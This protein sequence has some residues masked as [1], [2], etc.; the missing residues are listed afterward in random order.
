MLRPDFPFS[1]VRRRRAQ[2]A[3]PLQKVLFLEQ[4]QGADD[5]ALKAEFFR[6]NAYRQGQELGHVEDRQAK[7][8]PGGCFYLC[9]A[10]VEVAVAQGTGDHDAVGPGR[11]G[12]GE[13]VAGELQH[14]PGARQGEV[15]AAAF[16]PVAPA[17]R[18]GTCRLYD[19]LHDGGGLGA[20]ELGHVGWTGEA[21]PVVA[22]DFQPGEGFLYRAAEP[23]KAKVSGQDVEQVLHFF[24]GGYLCLDGVL[25]LAPLLG[26]L[27]QPV[28]G[29]LEAR[30]AGGARYRQIP[31][32]P[33]GELQVLGAQGEGEKLVD[34]VGRGGAAAEPV[35][36]FGEA[37]L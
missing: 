28:L 25:Y 29:G 16:E 14:D 34:V 35:R 13:D 36:D 1:S 30:E 22:G 37:D 26:V 6:G 11:L 24:I 19:P 3:A 2:H 27:G 15:G 18:F 7:A 5:H 20:V 23:L 12:R 10:D 17:D 4:W 33:L 32:Y 8:L 21:T 9:L 31:L